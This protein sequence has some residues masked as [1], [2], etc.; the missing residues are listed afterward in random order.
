MG[1][2]KQIKKKLV[3]YRRNLIDKASDY[4]K[5]LW[6]KQFPKPFIALFETPEKL[7]KQFNF[8]YEIPEVKKLPKK[9]R[10]DLFM[11]IKQKH[12]NWV[13]DI[14]SLE[15][16][17]DIIGSYYLELY[18]TQ[19]IQVNLKN[20]MFF[21][22]RAILECVKKYKFD[23]ALTLINKYNFMESA[24]IDDIFKIIEDRYLEA[25]KD[26]KRLAGRKSKYSEEE[27]N[28]IYKDSYISLECMPLLKW[29]N[30]LKFKKK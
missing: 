7:I 2:L 14:I 18:K 16:K 15:E 6:L 21:G 25:K 26:Y 9:E 11:R 1:K 8:Y 22:R 30:F 17:Y 27:A 5:Q 24:I 23:T 4:N 19:N 10:I 13:F 28:K 3:D 29:L 20:M 12:P